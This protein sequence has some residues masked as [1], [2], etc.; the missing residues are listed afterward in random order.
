MVF[1]HLFCRVCL[2]P[3]RT[4]AMMK[5]RKWFVNHLAASL[6]DFDVKN[7]DDDPTNDRQAGAK[8]RINLQGFKAFLDR[9]KIPYPDGTLRNY[10]RYANTTPEAMAAKPVAIQDLVGALSKVPE[11]P[12]YMTLL[13][14]EEV[15]KSPVSR[16]QRGFR[17][18]QEARAISDEPAPSPRK[19][20]AA[21]SRNFAV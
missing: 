10:L 17:K 21:S 15:A 20:A 18:V 14:P 19:G 5:K 16:W 7:M 13:Q 1:A 3:S 11:V 6:D 4:Q 8:S 12:L 9:E 2:P